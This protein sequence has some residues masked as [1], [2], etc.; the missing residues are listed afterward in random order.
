[1]SLVKGVSVGKPFA[2]RHSDGIGLRSCMQPAWSALRGVLA[3]VQ[4]AS[5]SR[6]MA[7]SFGQRMR[8]SLPGARTVRNKPE[9]CQ[10]L[11]GKAGLPSL[12]LPYL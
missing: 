3:H 6:H 12:S 1:M 9:G 10:T 7:L 2:D 11:A 4:R 8:P 5:L